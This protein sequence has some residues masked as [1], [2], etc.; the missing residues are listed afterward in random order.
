MD[1]VTSV[2]T[3]VGADPP[4]SADSP[5]M[6]AGLNSMAAVALVSHLEGALGGAVNLP[7]TLAFDYPTVTSM[8][9][10]LCSVAIPPVPPVATP[11]PSH[12]CS[13]PQHKHH[14]F[15]VSPVQASIHQPAAGGSAGSAFAGVLR[16]QVLAA[17][18]EV[19]GDDVGAAVAAAPTAPLLAAGVSSASAVQLT[20]ILEQQLNM[21]LPATLVFDYPTVDGIVAFLAQSGS[22]A[23]AESLPAAATISTG[24]H[25][26]LQ[27]LSS[28]SSSAAAAA[29]SS[30]GPAAGTV[31][32]LSVSRVSQIVR[33]A[34][35][36]ALSGTGVELVDVP[37]TAPLMSSGLNSSAAVQL[38]ADLESRLG[39]ELPG[40]LV[41]DHPSIQAL[42][43]Y[44]SQALAP[45]PQHTPPSSTSD[46]NCNNTPGTLTAQ[47]SPCP[48]CPSSS[49][50]Q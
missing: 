32:A 33:Q 8:A 13:P 43:D 42:S 21:Q 14:Q 7:S 44:I 39:L 40:T 16:R 46:I 49:D 23:P 15:R 47:L 29:A 26:A 31:Q 1:C 19:V 3:G 45:A 5:L 18:S 36:E 35:A 12:R 9:A 6:A 2:L 28:S 30:S 4:A 10:F 11:T 20:A 25:S 41:F 24:E 22:A 27:P 37:D 50:W 38:T 17:I 34:V 48:V